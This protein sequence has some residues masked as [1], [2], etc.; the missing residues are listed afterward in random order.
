MEVDELV[1]ALNLCDGSPYEY[2]SIEKVFSDPLT[3]GL[4][5]M[6]FMKHVNNMDLVKSFDV[7][8]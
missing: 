3:E 7:L 8:S 1:I 2:I 4:R 5:P 6:V